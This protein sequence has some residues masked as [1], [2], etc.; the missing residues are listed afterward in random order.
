[1]AIS[2]YTTSQ[3]GILQAFG[4]S[5]TG[6]LNYQANPLGGFSL[7]G[8]SGLFDGLLPET[9]GGRSISFTA[10]NWL[11]QVGPSPEFTSFGLFNG[12]FVRAFLP[13]PTPAASASTPQPPNPSTGMFG[14]KDYSAEKSA[15]LVDTAFKLATY[16]QMDKIF[17]INVGGIVNQ[18]GNV[19]PDGLAANRMHLELPAGWSKVAPAA[20]GLGQNALDPDGYYIIKSPLTG[21]TY[22]GPQAQILEQ[23][24]SAGHITGLSVTFIGTN[25]PVDVLDYLQLN[26]GEIAPNMEPLLNAVRDYAVAHHL[27]AQDVIVTGYS[28]GAA[29]TNVMARFA[30]S[31]SG[32]FFA[33]SNYIAYEVPYIYDQKDR[34]LNIGYE[35]DVV[36]RAAGDW[37]SLAQAVA[38]APGLIG[39][40]Y[41]LHS[42]TDNLVL[43]SDDYASPTWPAGP[44]A[45]YNIVGGWSAH[46]AGIT[47]D[48]LQR[49]M[50]SHFYEFTTRDSLVIVSNLSGLTRGTTWVQDLDRPSDRYDHVGDSAFIVGTAYDDKIAGNRGNDYIDGMD[51]NDIIR[52]G[53]GANRIEGGA[54][55]DTLQLQGTMSD[56]TVTKLSDGTLAFFSKSYGMNIVS[57]VEQVTFLETGPLHT[58]RNYDIVSDRLEDQTFSGS[59]EWLDQDVAFVKSTQGTAG[60]DV[61]TGKFVFG[62]AGDDIINGT[63]GNDVLYGGSGNDKLN[64]GAGNDFIYGGEGNDVLTGGGGNDLLNGGL[65]NDQFVFD[66]KLAGFVT[67]ED[68]RLSAD[69]LDMIVVKNSGYS[70]AAEL[71]SHAHQTADGVLFDFGSADLLIAHAHTSDITKDMLLLA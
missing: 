13:A 57:G 24:D 27:G 46:V 71:L 66:A 70:S 11:A 67:I 10:P 64:G 6:L 35:N 34:V 20:L 52:P 65:G 56:W 36:H 3:L 21:T 43:F 41:N 23:H 7:G 53:T 28:L 40:D 16:E 14:Y 9:Y 62:L 58:P 15:Q 4:L 60:N 48:G 39:Q 47:S 8:M 59:F 55:N 61:L 51:G 38:A 22:S 63:S 54:G 50:N 29:Y 37:G 30:D 68:F 69:E 2:N 44:F 42:S 32:G 45:L 49:I 5:P 1:M 19:M 33:N 25:S 26:S 12:T 18:I 31:L 17:G